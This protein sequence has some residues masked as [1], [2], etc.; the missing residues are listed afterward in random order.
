LSPAQP[1]RLKGLAKELFDLIHYGWYWGG[2]SKE[3]AE[4]KLKNE[5]DG[6]FIVR[7]SSSSV[8]IL[9]LSFNRLVTCKNELKRLIFIVFIL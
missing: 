5:P 4:E 2:L 8:H 9:S 1:N 7:D 3:E 6:A